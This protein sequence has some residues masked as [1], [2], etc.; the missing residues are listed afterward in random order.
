MLEAMMSGLWLIMD[1]QIIGLILFATLLGNFFGA[2]PGLG[3]NLGLALLIPF[4]FAL[5][6]TFLF[7]KD[8]RNFQR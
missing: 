8:L 4:V 3:G 5:K 2:V 1:W 6:K 7:Q